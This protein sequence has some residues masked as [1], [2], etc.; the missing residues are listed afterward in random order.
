MRPIQ[1]IDAFDAIAHPA[2]RAILVTL[3]DG[4]RAANELAEPFQ[5]TFAAIS[6]HV[7]VLEEAQLISVRRRSEFSP[8]RRAGGGRNATQ[9]FRAGDFADGVRPGIAQSQ[10]YSR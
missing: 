9:G 2:R 8:V 5:M 6:L 7:R 4:E 3:K 1:E 10:R